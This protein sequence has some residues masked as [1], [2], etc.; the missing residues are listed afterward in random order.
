MSGEL[1]YK[2]V[3]FERDCL[4]TQIGELRRVL[5]YMHEHRHSMQQAL[6]AAEEEIAF[7]KGGVGMHFVED[8]LA[9]KYRG[10]D[11]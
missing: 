9:G 4:S 8:A 11:I 1:E 3:V 5:N 6:R 2:R 10:D 7:L